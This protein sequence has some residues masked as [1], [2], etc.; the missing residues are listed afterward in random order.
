[1]AANSWNLNSLH[2]TVAEP[3][4][5]HVGA[6]RMPDRTKIEAKVREIWNEQVSRFIVL[7]DTVQSPE[8]AYSSC[9]RDL[10]FAKTTH[11]FNFQAAEKRDGYLS[12]RCSCMQHKSPL[13]MP[14]IRARIAKTSYLQITQ[15]T[16]LQSYSKCHWNNLLHYTIM[17]YS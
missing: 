17:Q 14:L 9:K 8:N 4:I 10:V 13:P 6:L 1:M 12:L 11:Y 2:Q 16:K 15:T 7:S 3:A 5:C